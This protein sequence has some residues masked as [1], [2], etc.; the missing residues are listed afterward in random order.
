MPRD[1]NEVSLIDALT[2]SDHLHILR[3]QF[4]P[5]FEIVVHAELVTELY[6][7]LY[8]VRCRPIQYSIDAL[9]MGY[10]T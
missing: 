6:S 8:I 7:V 9:C 2:V 5:T 1:H 10:D 3:T 4:N